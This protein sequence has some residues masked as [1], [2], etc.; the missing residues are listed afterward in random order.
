ME[1]WMFVT[2]SSQWSS[3]FQQQPLGS[4]KIW[5]KDWSSA[6]PAPSK[7]TPTPIAPPPKVQVTPAPKVVGDPLE[8][9]ATKLAKLFVE[10]GSDATWSA[11]TPTN[12]VSLPTTPSTVDQED[13]EDED[14][15][16]TIEDE[17]SKQNLY[18]TELCRSFVDTGICRYGHRCQFA[19]GEH[20][21]RPVLRHPKYKTETC[22]SFYMTGSCRYGSRCRFIHTFPPAQQEWSS[23]WDPVKP[24][25]IL[26]SPTA[27]E[28]LVEN[29]PKK[30]E[31]DIAAASRRLAIF[32]A[33]A[34]KALTNN[35]S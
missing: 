9:V 11:A 33:L 2:N 27:P 4:S 20:E 16:S 34:S 5:S 19:H 25:S 13:E 6:V 31:D 15:K 29:D 12:K 35:S 24:N 22:R 28:T 26:S 14:K 17:L 32:E 21:L 23:S 10:Q 7:K 8:D 3:S 30:I 1:P 18:K